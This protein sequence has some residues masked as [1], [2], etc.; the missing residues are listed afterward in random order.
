MPHS[1]CSSPEHIASDIVAAFIDHPVLAETC[2]QLL[3]AVPQSGLTNR[4]FR[5]ST[6]TGDYFLR[7]PR[8]ETASMIDRHAEA[9]NLALA[10][11]LGLA[12]PAIYCNP[13]TGILLT[14]AV[15][16]LERAPVGFANDL[17]KS[18]GRLHSTGGKFHGKLDPASVYE[19]QK[20][21]LN[22]QPDL[23]KKISALD[24]A[25]AKNNKPAFAEGDGT[26]LVPSHG[27]LSPGNCLAVGSGIWLIDW[28]YSGMSL[29]AWDLAYAI[30]ENGFTA[31]DE[32]LFLQGYAT[33]GGRE[34]LPTEGQLNLMKSRCDA[35]SGLWALEQVARGR[36][37]ATFRPFAQD[38]IERALGRLR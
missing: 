34:L 36:D 1:S 22:Q 11:E 12:L 28:E 31:E 2:G 14:G 4:V 13:E 8:A 27:D 17:G 15:E 32:Q 21:G 3:E 6:E 30:L 37:A 5:L 35:V 7:L 16:T 9:H 19:T 23:L 24:A 25:L 26:F 33:A 10:A 20:S 38:R 29:P 18:V